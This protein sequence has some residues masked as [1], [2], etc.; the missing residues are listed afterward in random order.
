MESKE[1]VKNIKEI[2]KT[3]I[4]FVETTIK[5]GLEIIKEIIPY[6]K[7]NVLYTIQ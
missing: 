4:K 2:T 7:I 3:C 5:R 1:I 6:H